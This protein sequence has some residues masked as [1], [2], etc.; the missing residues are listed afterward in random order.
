MHMFDI[1]VLGE[2]NVD[3]ILSG[4]A[5]PEFGQ[6]E[7]VIQD[8][9]LAIGGS[10]TIFA[11]GAAR[12]GLRVAYCGVVG[13]DLFGRYMLEQLQARKID[14]TGVIVDPSLKTGMTVILHHQGDRALL[15]YLGAINRLEAEMVDRALLAQARHVHVS[16]YFLQ[17]ALQ[18]GL[19]DLLAA[20][21]KQGATVS[22]DTNWD[23][24]ERWDSGLEH[25]W[26][27]VD[28]FLPN[29]QEALAIARADSLEQALDALAARLPLVAV[30]RGA[31]GAVARQ[32]GQTVWDPG[33][34]VPVVDTTG[35]GDSFDA[36]FVYGFLHG[37]PLVETLGLACACGALSTRA[38]GGT[39]AQPTLD[40][41]KELLHSRQAP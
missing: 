22:M 16:S 3:L 41:A 6:V 24:A 17:R 20:A 40:E 21:H 4:D 33:F 7:K 31:Q 25:L 8:A 39:E 5:R 37:W 32:D 15:T 29:E 10:G 1:L 23:P 35:A 26:P 2:I 13:Q 30:K 11:C 27:H 28:L 19:A 9:T 18:P 38:P 36:G 34:T 14:T 12:L